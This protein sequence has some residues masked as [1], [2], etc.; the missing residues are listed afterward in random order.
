MTALR[1]QSGVGVGNRGLDLAAVAHYPD[2]TEQALDIGRAE[3]RNPLRGEAGEGAAEALTLPQDGEPREAGL[4]AL[5]AD[6][7]EQ[8][9]VVGDGPAP[10]AVVV[11]LVVGCA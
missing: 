6:F 8:P 5:Q 11:R 3:F 9:Y 10:L 7:L 2:I 1:F 4:E